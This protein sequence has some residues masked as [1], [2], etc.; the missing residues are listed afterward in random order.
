MKFLLLLA[1][2]AL[3]SRVCKADGFNWTIALENVT[4]DLSEDV[5]RSEAVKFNY[6]YFGVM[7]GENANVTYQFKI[8]EFGCDD[9]YADDTNTQSKFIYRTDDLAGWYVEDSGEDDLTVKVELDLAGLAGDSLVWT[10]GDTTATL[11]FCGRLEVYYGDDEGGRNK[12]FVNF[13]ETDV[14]ATIDLL[15]DGGFDVQEVHFNMIQEDESTDYNKDVEVDYELDVFHCD[16]D[17]HVLVENPGD[18]T[19]V[20]QGDTV[21][22]CVKVVEGTDANVFVEDIHAFTYKSTDENGENVADIVN[23][24]TAGT[25][26]NLLTDV[27]CAVVAGVCRIKFIPAASL[28]ADASDQKKDLEVSGDALIYIG[29]DQSTGGRRLVNKSLRSLVTS[30]SQGL[31]HYEYNVGRIAGMSAAATDDELQNQNDEGK[32]SA[33]LIVGVACVGLAVVGAAAFVA[34][35]FLSGSSAAVVVPPSKMVDTPTVNSSPNTVNG[36]S[37][38]LDVNMA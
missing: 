15:E 2:L 8:Y 12:T 11:F 31:G 38:M 16:P 6:H 36:D 17:T 37:L 18:N 26:N 27:N 5:D 35:S 19:T 23:A 22:I 33:G 21:S 29:E 3:G 1:L 28:F 34:V 20:R 30:G 14:N 13:H 24:I 7:A 10:Q 25:I 4:V 32:A 9:L